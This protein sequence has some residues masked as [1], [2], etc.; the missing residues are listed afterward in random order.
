[1]TDNASKKEVYAK[2]RLSVDNGFRNEYSYVDYRRWG[3]MELWSAGRIK[4]DLSARLASDI[5]VWFNYDLV[6][7]FSSYP[8]AIKKIKELKELAPVNL[9]EF[10]HYLE[11][12]K[13]R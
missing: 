9:G 6:G 11:I 13:A 3:I 8:E 1:M 5:E 12:G 10:W 7:R 2:F 4:A